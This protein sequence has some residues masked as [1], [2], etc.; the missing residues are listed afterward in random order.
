[1]LAEIAACAPT[2]IDLRGHGARRALAARSVGQRERVK[3][4]VT[5]ADR[6]AVSSLRMKNAKQKASR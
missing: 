1:V 5:R 2:A 3:M 6:E 4:P